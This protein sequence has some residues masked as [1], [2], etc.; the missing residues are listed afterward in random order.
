MAYLQWWNHNHNQQKKNFKKTYT[1]VVIEIKMKDNVAEKAST[2]VA[3]ID[4]G[5]KVL[6]IFAHVI[7][8]TWIIDS[9][10]TDHTT[11]DSR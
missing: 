8:S 3:A 11:F 9:G 10:T 4:N 6:N 5:G 2:L 1:A 7:N